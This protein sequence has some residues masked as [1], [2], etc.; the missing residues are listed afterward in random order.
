MRTTYAVLLCV[1]LLLLSA[2]AQKVNDPADVQAIRKSL[3][4]YAK[5]VNARDID[6]TVALM[7]DNAT[8]AGL[9][10]PVATGK[11]AIRSMHTTWFS[12]AP[13]FSCPVEDV[14][15]V[16]DQAVA[17]GNWTD[18][19][20]PKAQGISPYS[21]S[22][23]WVVVLARQRD[24]SWKWDWCLPS[25]NQPL[26]GRTASGEDEQALLQIERDLGEALLKKDAAAWDKVLAKEWIYNTDGQLITRTQMLAEIK[27]G[28]YKLAAM[29]LTDLS[30]HVFGD[31]AVVSMTA[32]MKGKY[33]GSDIPSPQRSTDFFVKR[34]GRWQAV[35]T[36]NI[37][38]K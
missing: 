3:E 10:A 38:I 27:S 12:L 35:S 8:Y 18:K 28:A 7:T 11:G 17:K 33:K 22:G 15:V 24:G 13:E 26:P 2:C 9:N 14:R 32:V 36:Q 34:D 20:T 6:A 37:T 1:L 19:L 16:G 29:E 4:D 23:S 21:D 5:A 30:P 25:S 31:S